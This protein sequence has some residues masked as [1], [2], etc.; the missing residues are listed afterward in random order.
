[1]LLDQY[2]KP[3]PTPAQRMVSQRRQRRRAEIAAAYDAAQTTSENAQHWRWA[4][5]LSA[6]E[7]NSSE[8]RR[9]IRE[10]ARYEVANNSYASGIV[11]TLSNTTIGTGPRL[12]M[13]TLSAEINA[14][15][16]IRWKQWCDQVRLAEK[17]RTAHRAR[18]VDGE[19]FIQF[20]TN[21][22]AARATTPVS[23]DLQVLECDQFEDVNQ[24]QTPEHTA[25]IHFDAY[26]NPVRYDMLRY[27]PGDAFAGWQQA[28][29]VD[30]DDLIHMFRCD[31]PGQIRGIS[32]LTPAL[33]LFAKLRRFTLAV[34]IGAEV[35][36]DHAAVL[37][38]Q[39]PPMDDEYGFDGDDLDPYDAAPIDRGM[40]TVLPRG[41][42]LNQ[43]KPE[44]PTTN[45]EMFRN[46][47]LNEIARCLGMP[48][49]VAAGT[50]KGMN[51]S[52]GQLDHGFFDDTTRVDRST[53]TTNCLERIFASWLDEALLIPGYL[54]DLEGHNKYGLPHRFYWDGRTHGDPA[55][56]AKATDT[57]SKLGL[58]T[59]EAYLIREGID[60]EE[61]HQQMLRQAR[62]RR[63]IAEIAGPPPVKPDPATPGADATKASPKPVAA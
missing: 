63:E 57:L 61:H 56:Q 10:R 40:M 47:I 22:R 21:P 37:E 55:K 11:D 52:S 12:Q 59:D 34:L 18:T 53:W 44:Q 13:L 31:R 20:T 6:A 3:M 45:F 43:L 60:P 32:A 4:D 19:S 9:T 25:G 17:L 36:A 39:G 42:K 49:N 2:G 14:A 41:W 26:R 8:I 15:I 33:P 23:L 48:F 7:A 54:P 28:E 24:S 35:A 5:S 58:L 30:A 51:Y 62:R 29:P 38:T 46:A 50:S 1:M 27:H 16:E